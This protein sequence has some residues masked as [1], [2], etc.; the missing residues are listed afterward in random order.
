MEACEGNPRRYAG[1]HAT[2]PERRH[3][4]IHAGG[5]ARGHVR[6]HACTRACGHACR[7]PG[8]YARRPDLPRSHGD[9]PWAV[10]VAVCSRK[11]NWTARAPCTT[12]PPSVHPPQER[13]GCCRRPPGLVLFDTKLSILFLGNDYFVNLWVIYVSDVYEIILGKKT[14]CTK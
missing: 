6:G 11:L 9:A 4:R 7:H 8:R 1:R 2:R 10:Y 5:H 13:P 14:A 3:A 12:A